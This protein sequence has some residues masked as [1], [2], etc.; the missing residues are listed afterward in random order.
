MMTTKKKAG[1]TL[2][3]LLVVITIIGILIALLLPAVQAAREAARRMHC[4]NNL[5]QMGLAANQYLEMNGVFPASWVNGEER[6]AWA[7]SLLPYLE[8]N[9]LYDSWDSSIGFLEGRNGDLAATYLS[10]Y[11]CPSA[12]SLP[13]Y[14]YERSGFPPRYGT[15]D[16]KGCDGVLAS[17]PILTSWGRTG[18]VR[19]VISR[20]PM[21][22]ARI[23]DGLSNTIL[24]VES[25]GGTDLFGPGGKPGTPDR[26]WYPTDGAWVG[27]SLSGL[28]PTVGAIAIGLTTPGGINCSNMYDHGPYSFHPGG[29]QVVFC[30]GSVHFLAENLEPFVLCCMYAYDDGK[31]LGAF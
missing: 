18:W 26:I 28:F 20:V 1:F 5:K 11:K 30:D 17:D 31:P 29:A 12:P 13:V 10:V 3:E 16:Y 9:A 2:I 8:Q 23:Q 7:R 22:S 4:A 27:R 19:G 14:S 15:N 21:S 24:L 6:I 25:V